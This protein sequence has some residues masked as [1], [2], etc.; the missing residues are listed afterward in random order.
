MEG[1]E[2]VAVDTVTVPVEGMT[3]EHCR[4]AVADEV[5][6]V[7]GVR[8]VAVDLGAKQVV[9]AGD[10]LDGDRIRAAIVE[11][12]YE[13]GPVTVPAA[14]ADAVPAPVVAPAAG[15]ASAA[16]PAAETDRGGARR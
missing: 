12:G 11:A 3:C 8:S 7:P 4:R 6:A 5:A 14:A 1:V 16:P 2:E 13:P 9:V 10:A 15:V